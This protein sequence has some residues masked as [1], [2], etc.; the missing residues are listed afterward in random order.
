METYSLVV[1]FSQHQLFTLPNGGSEKGKLTLREVL[2]L[3]APTHV[4]TVYK[5]ACRNTFGMLMYFIPGRMKTL[6]QVHYKIK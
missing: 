2:P 1:R 4:H 6:T 5:S 3:T